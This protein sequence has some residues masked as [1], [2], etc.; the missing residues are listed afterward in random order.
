[1]EE[2]T[3]KTPVETCPPVVTTGATPMVRTQAKE[4]AHMG[5]AN[6]PIANLT[7]AL[8]HEET[9]GAAH[10]GGTL[11]EEDQILTA[12]AAPREEEALQGEIPMGE[13]PLDGTL[14]GEGH[15]ART[16]IEAE[17]HQEE[18]DH[19]EDHR[20]DHLA[21]LQ[22]LQDLLGPLD[23]LIPGAGTKTEGDRTIT[24]TDGTNTREAE[25]PLATPITTRPST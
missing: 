20:V 19:L 16:P 21:D 15:Q 3:G 9:Q 12:E 14:M 13:D 8:L 22:D 18:E 11:M 23:L 6:H 2:G 1:M 5:E 17:D 4:P 10:L 24:V 7:E 25:D